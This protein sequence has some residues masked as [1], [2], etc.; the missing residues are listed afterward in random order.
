MD[1]RRQ[2]RALAHLLD[3]HDERAF[4][5]HRATGHRHSGRLRHQ[6]ALAGEQRLVG[7][8]HAF[9]NLAV[10]RHDIARSHQHNIAGVKVGDHALLGAAVDR[11]IGHDLSEGRQQLGQRLGD[12]HRL[13][14]RRHLKIATAEQEKYEH[15]DRIEIH[16]TVLDQR[17]PATRQEGGADAKRHRHVHADPAQLEI[18]PGIAEERGS[19][20]EDHRQRQQQASPTHQA[21]D[22]GRH[23]ALGQ[24]DRDRVHHHLHHAETG[25]P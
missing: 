2:A 17:R 8:T 4:R 20:I 7:R 18:A 13:L 21:L 6:P 10:G 22:V 15:G 24:I 23:V 5:I 16:R 19:G 11:E 9:D 14:A 25:H 3:A 1:D 12:A